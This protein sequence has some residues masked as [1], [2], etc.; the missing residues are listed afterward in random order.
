MG[1]RRKPSTPSRARLAVLTTAVAGGAVLAAGTAH[2]EPAPSLATVKEQVDKLNEEAEQAIERFN[3]FQ[4]KQRKLQ[5]EANQI[6][7]KVVRG[8][9]AMNELRTRLGAVAADQ[10]RSNGIDPSVQLMLDSD[11]A[12][13]L[14]RASAQNQAAGSQAALLKEAQGEQRKLDQDRAEATRTLAELETVGGQLA[15]EKQQVQGKLAQAQA[16]LNKLSAEER[17]KI[18]AQESAD[19]ARAA[20]KQA[21]D[22]DRASRSTQRTDLNAPPPPAASGRAAT[23]V[24]FAYAQLGKP[25]EW[26]ATGPNSFDCSGLTGAAYRAAGVKLS[27]MSQDQWNDGPRVARSDLQAGDLVFFYGDIH[28]VGIYIG[29]GKMIHAPRTGK[30]VEVLP[31][32]SMPYVGAVRPA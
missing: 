7:E 22:A 26:S 23:I 6:Q 18:N 15:G 27:R 25:Y 2:A 29:D 5:G 31:I 19:K 24:Q 30:N 10:Y 12:S 17:A 13:Y 1:K 4:E 16:L 32:D 21:G 28:H 14:E 9:A 11:P 3:G 8:Q 20:A